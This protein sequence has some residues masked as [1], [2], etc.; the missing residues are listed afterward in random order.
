MNNFKNVLEII[1]EFNNR[2]RIEDVIKTV[3]GETIKGKSL[4]CPIHRG[5]N[6]HGASINPRTNVFSC[7]TSDCG[8]GLT[9]WQFVKKYYNLSTFKEVAQKVNQLF[10]A[11][12]PIYNK[13]KQNI[14]KE[15]FDVVYNV[16]RY[17]SEANNMIKKELE[18]CNHILLNAN[19]GLGKTYAIVDFVTKNNIDDYVFFLVPTRSIAEQVSKDYPKFRLF[20]D[21]DTQLPASRFIVSTYHKIYHLQRAVERETEQCCLLNEFPP[22]YMVIIDEVHEIMSK[23][24]LLSVKARNI[25]LFLKNAD[26]SILMS[27]NTDYVYRAYKDKNMFNKYICVNRRNIE[28]NANNL[29]IHHYHIF[30]LKPFV[31]LIPPA[32]VIVIIYSGRS[33]PKALGNLQYFLNRV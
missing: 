5:N 12:I 6:K 21:N 26:R 23:R 33:S 3:S 8:R 20:Y 29:N 18:E 14:T 32:V 9:P 16:D 11:N 1:E 24:K 25:E 15:E 2:N 10:N 22:S 4:C 7:W 27:A 30:Y 13:N 17:L 19:T 31:T 28:Y